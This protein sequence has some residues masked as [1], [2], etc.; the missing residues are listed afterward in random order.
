MNRIEI[1]K[2]EDQRYLIL[3]VLNLGTLALYWPVTGSNFVNL[4][5][6][7]YV[8]ANP[9]VANGI[10]LNGI[11]SA[12]STGQAA[13]WHPLTWLSHM[14]DC[15]L[16]GMR[17]GLHHLTNVW[18]HMANSVMLFLILER[19][20]A[21][22]WRSAIVAAL[23][24]WHP[25]H[26][27][28]VAWI[29]ERKDV[30]STFFLFAALLAYISYARLPSVLRYSKVMFLFALSLMSKQMTVTAPFLLL[31]LDFWPLGRVDSKRASNRQLQ[32]TAI[33]CNS[34][35]V[36]F[37]VRQLIIEKLPLLALSVAAGA[38]TLLA[39]ATSM[40]P[41]EA[42]PLSARIGNALTA[43]VLYLKNM[44]WPSQLTVMYLHTGQALPSAI[45]IAVFLLALISVLCFS[46]RR[47]RPYLSVGWA[48]FITA[49]LPVIG[50]VQVGQQSMADRYTYVPLIGVF[51]MLV[52][53]GADFL[54][55]QRLPKAVCVSL[56]A[57]IVIPLLVSSHIQL[58]HW[59][60]PVA[61]WRHAVKCEPYNYVAHQNLACALGDAGATD[62]ALT[63]FQR[64]LQ[65][66]AAD[67]ETHS[68]FG[69]FLDKAGKLEGAVGQFEL[70]LELAPR[71][72]EAH[73]NL[74]LCLSRQ[75]KHREAVAHYQKAL[76]IKPRYAEA[77]NNLAL[78]LATQSEA[79]VRD[80]SEAL[81]HSKRACELTGR[82]EPM[83]LDTLAAAQARSGDFSEAI[84][85]AEE[86]LRLA[87]ATKRL[88][89]AKTIAEHLKL[90]RSG[91]LFVVAVD[92]A[93]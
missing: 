42:L 90:Y 70:A 92:P 76:E 26:V 68:S 78:L 87:T 12:F 29:S 40:A 15:Q 63:E 83:F 20:T 88:E 5:D 53:M 57:F 91:K 66:N 46:T 35:R 11:L 43:Y 14:L 22:I 50:I 16:F 81:M 41:L 61:L 71:N 49:L 27:E 36:R 93:Y 67:P 54:S 6:P 79:T 32:G 56:G 84:A 74:A 64:A 82:R 85:V 13:N 55:D 10:T 19:M 8:M 25:L 51:V 39:Q 34:N 37:S 52:W 24:A 21:A 3:A 62:E 30:L 1:R 69:C 60:N 31:L 47:G 58:K 18:L 80:R 73:N 45:T 89:Q 28:S 7:E 9:M 48:W 44:L 75:G 86:G 72:A 38:M 59:A 4:D 65:L 33:N 17:P 2:I 77:H 23:F